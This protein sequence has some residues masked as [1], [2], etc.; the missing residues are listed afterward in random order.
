MQDGAF[1]LTLISL[2]WSTCANSHPW[3][4]CLAYKIK[5]V[6]ERRPLLSMHG[7]VSCGIPSTRRDIHAFLHIPISFNIYRLS[8]LPKRNR[9]AVNSFTQAYQLGL[10]VKC[11][12]VL[13]T[14]DCDYLWQVT[15][16]GGPILVIVVIPFSIRTNLLE[17]LEEN[18]SDD[19]DNVS[20]M[21]EFQI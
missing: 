10:E 17:N 14:P 20:F 9:Y 15:V 7:P 4:T 18:L 16:K 3:R 13:L 6:D 11:N 21:C 19:K 5:W 2:L 12:I 8:S 1:K